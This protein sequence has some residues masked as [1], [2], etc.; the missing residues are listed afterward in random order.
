[1]MEQIIIVGCKYCNSDN[2]VKDGIRCTT[3]RDIQKFRCNTCRRFFI[4]NIGFEDDTQP[5]ELHHQCNYFNVESLRN[6][7]HSLKLI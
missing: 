3:H 4:I 1:M 5:R 6:V 2:L 7:V